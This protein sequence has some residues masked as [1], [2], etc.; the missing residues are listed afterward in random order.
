M[1]MRAYDLA[2][3][4]NSLSS[5]E[6][7]KT[8]WRG[9]GATTLTTRSTQPNHPSSN[10]NALSN[11]QVKE[12][13]RNWDGLITS[14]VGTRSNLSPRCNPRSMTQFLVASI[15]YRQ[16]EAATIFSPKVRRCS[17]NRRPGSSKV[18]GDKRP[19]KSFDQPAESSMW[20][21]YQVRHPTSKWKRSP[22]STT[23]GWHRRNQRLSSH[24]QTY[25][26]HKL[27]PT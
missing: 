16:M 15:T 1:L 9:T 11:G 18:R 4:L 27:G 24:L 7:S 26:T 20:N 3:R 14:Q 21:G 13:R 22:T 8:Q 17:W 6:V 12:A 5:K 23:R 19:E 25:T 2:N 10:L